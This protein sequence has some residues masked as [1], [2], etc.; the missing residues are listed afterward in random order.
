[1][2]ELSVGST[3]TGTEPS[4]FGALCPNVLAITPQWRW[5]AYIGPFLHN[6]TCTPAAPF[7]TS[8]P[9]VLRF[10]LVTSPPSPCFHDKRSGG[11]RTFCELAPGACLPRRFNARW[12]LPQCL[13]HR[14]TRSQTARTLTMLRRCISIGD[15]IPSRSIPRGQRISR[16]WSRDCLVPRH[17]TLLPV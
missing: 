7:R 8:H 12:Q 10:F 14:M 4:T 3:G 1:M 15:R 6:T 16:V 13:L 5:S 17:S 9:H 11:S 2:D